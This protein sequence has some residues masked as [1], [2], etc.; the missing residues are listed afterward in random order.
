MKR[1]SH[2]LADGKQPHLQTLDKQ[3]Q[4]DGDEQDA[5]QQ[6]Q[7]IGQRLADDQQLKNTCHQHDGHEVTQAARH[8]PQRIWQMD[9]PHG[10]KHNKKTPAAAGF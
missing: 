10:K 9:S 7:Q 6:I 5:Q 3:T 8:G 2:G 4:A 1:V